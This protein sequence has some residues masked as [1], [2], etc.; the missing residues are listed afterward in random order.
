MSDVKEAWYAQE[1]ERIIKAKDQVLLVEIL[2]VR[3][4]ACALYVVATRKLTDD[5]PDSLVV[6]WLDKEANNRGKQ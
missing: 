1:A 2:R 4:A 6:A 3:D 5:F